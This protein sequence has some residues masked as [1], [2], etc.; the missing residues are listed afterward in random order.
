VRGAGEDEAVVRGEVVGVA[1]TRDG[2]SGAVRRKVAPVPVVLPPVEAV[3]VEE[4]AVEE[5]PVPPPPVEEADDGLLPVV[6]GKAEFAGAG[7]FLKTTDG[8]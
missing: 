1:T 7:P 5:A 3:P 6:R 2:S 8:A 4:A